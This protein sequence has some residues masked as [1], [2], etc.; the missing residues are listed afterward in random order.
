MFC[1]FGG[2]C[3]W[4]LLFF[5]LGSDFHQFY[6]LVILFVIFKYFCSLISLTVKFSCSLFLSATLYCLLHHCYNHPSCTH[7]RIQ[8]KA[9][10]FCQVL[11]D[12]TPRCSW[13]VVTCSPG[14][15]LFLSAGAASSHPTTTNVTRCVLK[16]N[17]HTN[18]VVE[19]GG[20]FMKD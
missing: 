2:L 6:G 18:K 15:S 16:C 4:M 3:V 11:T 10:V 19:I 12:S 8:I 13:V 20:L 9:L 17:S 7:S 1:V 5:F 14:F